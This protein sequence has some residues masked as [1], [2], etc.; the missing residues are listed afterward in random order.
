MGPHSH[1][2][3]IKEYVRI[4]VF[5]PLISQLSHPHCH[6]LI[7]LFPSGSIFS[8]ISYLLFFHCFALQLHH[9]FLFEN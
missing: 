4:S 1:N 8:L 9:I 6:S 3:L 7:L 2:I 5:L